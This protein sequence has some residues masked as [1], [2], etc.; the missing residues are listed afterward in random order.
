MFV[1]KR[2]S[3]KQRSIRMLH[4][5]WSRSNYNYQC[6]PPIVHLITNQLLYPV[7][8][9]VRGGIFSAVLPRDEAPAPS[10]RSGQAVYFGRMGSLLRAGRRFTSGGS[11]RS[12]LSCGV[13]KA[14][15]RKVTYG[16][17]RMRHPL[18]DSTSSARR[19]QHGARGVGRNN[20]I[21]LYN[22]YNNI[23]Y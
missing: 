1:V 2:I 8:T 17:E 6:I 3:L 22:Y 18:P 19:R 9:L 20:I 23:L 14:E 21:P 15:R 7:V 11:L 12:G 16:Q 4:S 10:A 13:R 5:F